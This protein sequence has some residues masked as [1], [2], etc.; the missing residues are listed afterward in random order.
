MIAQ[1]E[2][3][4]GKF[5]LMNAACAPIASPVSF[6]APHLGIGAITN[7]DNPARGVRIAVHVVAATITIAIVKAILRSFQDACPVP[8]VPTSKNGTEKCVT[9]NT[10][11]PILPS[12]PSVSSP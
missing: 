6:A 12:R 11:A 2:T 7:F 8:V 4:G 10:S 1:T 3:V 5:A 9:Q